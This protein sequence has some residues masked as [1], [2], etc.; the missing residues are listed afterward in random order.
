LPLL[1]YVFGSRSKTQSQDEVVFLLIPHLVRESLLSRM[2]TR[3]IDTGTSQSIEL[4]REAGQDAASTRTTGAAGPGGSLV[5]PAQR[6]TAAAAANAAI[7]Q[8]QQDGSA[9]TSA[10][11][12][13]PVSFAITPGNATQAVGSTFQVAVMASNARDLYSVPLQMQFNPQVLQLVNVDSGEMLG[14]DGQAVALAHRDE[15]NGMVT[16][17]ASRPPSTKGVDGQGSICVLTFKATAAGDSNLMLTKVGA[18]N[19][20]QVNLPAVGS[21]AIVHVK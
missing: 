12:A 6:T 17:S 19:S 2:N 14:R 9:T 13:A 5:P 11:V 7:Q 3:A 8:L 20:A 10:S 16:I 21:Q 18:Q 1:K 4:R 15:G